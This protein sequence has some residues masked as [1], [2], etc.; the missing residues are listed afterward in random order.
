MNS[1][2]IFLI[3]IFIFSGITV[4]IIP[5]LTRKTENFG[6]SIP[7]RIYNQTQFI[8]MRKQYSWSMVSLL[9][10]L[11]AILIIIGLYMSET[12]FFVSFTIIL[13][14]YLLASFII[15]L[16]FHF[17]MKEIKER[18]N[19]TEQYKE[20]LIIDTSFRDERITYSNWLFLIP[21]FIIIL[22]IS[23]TFLIYD[24]I[25]DEVPRHISV[26]GKIT[27]TEK[28][29]GIL[30]MLPFT[31]LFMLGIFLIINYVIKQSKQQV[32]ATNPEVSKKQ[33]IIF[34]KR[35]SLYTF[36]MGTFTILLLSFLQLTFIYEDWIKY[37][38]PV[39]YTSIVFIL[40]GTVVLSIKTGQGGSRIKIKEEEN[41][42]FIERDN[43]KH[44]KL[45]QFYFNKNDPAIFIEKRFGIGWSANF[46]RPMTWILIISIIILSLFPLIFTLF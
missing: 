3:F 37:I 41:D 1:T 7:E 29:P 40:V 5:F 45:G 30:L 36:I 32:S 25:P 6:V 13:M 19:W 46:A 43:D 20:T 10:L 38:D 18:E 11:T 39:M 33:N 15:Y 22:T 4:S 27:Y 9:I 24:T 28:S 17:K 34:R 35:W 12:T 31:Q 21:L 2:F 42:Q 14:S 8:K 16:P 44:W 26:T 23:Y